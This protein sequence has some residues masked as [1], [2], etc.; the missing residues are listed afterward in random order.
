VDFQHPLERRTRELESGG[1][2]FVGT[3]K[4]DQGWVSQCPT[5][6]GR[7]CA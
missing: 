2:D 6:R 4:E 7:V 1:H 5:R 3:I